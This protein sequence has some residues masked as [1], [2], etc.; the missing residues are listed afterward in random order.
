MPKVMSIEANIPLFYG[1]TVSDIARI[2]NQ[3]QS[4][5][6]KRISGR[7]TPVTPPGEKPVRYKLKDAARYM[8]ELKIDAHVIEDAIKKMSPEKL[9]PKL[10]QVFWQGQ[11]SRLEFQERQGQLWKSERVVGILADVFKPMSITIRMFQ[12][13]VAQE[14]ELTDTQK[15]RITEL[16]DGLLRHLQETLI[17]NFKDYRPAPD[18]HGDP[19]SEAEG[20]REID[21]EIDEEDEDDGFGD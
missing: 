1:A 19:L 2:F 3:S 8:V 16:S 6:Q 7:I 9:P 12:D 14:C 11:K 13:T 21:I 20:D 4:E 10:T 15:E 18:E 17:E 5:V